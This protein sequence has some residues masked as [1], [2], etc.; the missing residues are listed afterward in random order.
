MLNK[1]GS[2]SSGVARLKKTSTSGAISELTESR[3]RSNTGRRDLSGHLVLW[4]LFLTLMDPPLITLAWIWSGGIV[5][6]CRVCIL[7]RQVENRKAVVCPV[8]LGVPL[9]P[10][11]VCVCVK[12]WG[13]P[14]WWQWQQWTV[15]VQDEEQ[16]R[17][18]LTMVGVGG[19]YSFC[20]WLI[21]QTYHIPKMY[22]NLF[23]LEEV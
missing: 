14:V 16:L 8:N 12:S 17:S 10:V 13:H 15:E 22:F 5:L 23:F 7:E 21:S 9:S 11:C 18:S 2:A 4:M 3:L 20:L 19:C 6:T 1:P